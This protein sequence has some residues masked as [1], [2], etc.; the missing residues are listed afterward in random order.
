VEAGFPFGRATKKD[1][2]ARKSVLAVFRA[3][4]EAPLNHWARSRPAARPAHKCTRPEI[5]PAIARL[6]APIIP[7]LGRFFA[8]DSLSEFFS[9]PLI[10]CFR[11]PCH[12]IFGNCAVQQAQQNYKRLVILALLLFAVVSSGDAVSAAST[13]ASAQSPLL[14]DGKP[15]PCDPQLDQP[16]YISGVDVNGNPVVSADVPTA[17]NPVPEEVL[18]PLN[19]K[20]GDGPVA[21]LDGRAL[22]RLLNPAPSCAPR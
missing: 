13:V 6:S 4:P 12:E 14:A 21:A 11:P 22:N 15:G 1:S 16:D 9:W 8:P 10:Q 2:A 5:A 17:R 3:A 18:V 20:R 19:Q 7:E